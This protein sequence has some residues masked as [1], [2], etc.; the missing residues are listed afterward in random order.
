MHAKENARH[1]NAKE[2]DMSKILTDEERFE[3]EKKLNAD[4]PLWEYRLVQCPEC[5]GEGCLY[6]GKQGFV[7]EQFEDEA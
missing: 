5:G 4:S 2:S 1:V 6:C 3:I 7:V